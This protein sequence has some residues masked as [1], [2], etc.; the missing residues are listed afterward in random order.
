[1]SQENVE[2]VRMSVD[3][4]NRGDVEGVLEFY[5]PDVVFE[6]QR[7]AVQGA[8]RGHAGVREWM[9]DTAEN[10]SDFRLD[11]DHRD[12]G[13]GRVLSV[14][15][16]HLRG[17]GSGVET[18]VP[19]ATIATVREGRIVRNKDYGDRRKALEAAGLPE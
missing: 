19:V 7:A 4:A 14:G 16:L 15:S 18:E 10:F 6:P 17:Q 11:L 5:D 1:M 3:A 13:E 8:Y 12:L 9:A 2:V